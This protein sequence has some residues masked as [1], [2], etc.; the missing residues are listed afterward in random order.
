MKKEMSGMKKSI[1][2]CAILCILL[3]CAAQAEGYPE[4]NFEKKTVTLNS[5]YEMPIL[6]I[7]TYALSDSQAEE[8]TRKTFRFRGPTDYAKILTESSIEA[9]AIS[10]NHIMDFGKQ[11]YESTRKTL[12][13]NGIGRPSTYAPTISTIIGRGY[14]TREKKRLYP[15]ELG[16]TVTSMMEEYFSRIMDTEFTAEM[17][18]R[19]DEVEEGK[20]DLSPKDREFLERLRQILN[21]NLSNEEFNATSLAEKLGMSYTKFYY[22][23]KELLGTTPQDFL[24]SF[25][26]SRAMQLLQEHELNVSEVCYKVG[27]G[28]VAGF[29]RSFKNKYGVSPSSV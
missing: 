27:F 8:D 18:S 19:L 17:E 11:G 4:F 2:I 6:G 24:I 13:E 5:G 12:E 10:N 25:R 20:T 15:T 29:S 9:C 23:V 1:L 14:V 16:N 3:A 22:K 26:L 7:G 28:S 21:E